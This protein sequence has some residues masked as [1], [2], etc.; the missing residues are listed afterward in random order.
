MTMTT[1]NRRLSKAA[2]KAVKSLRRQ[3]AKAAKA[4]EASPEMIKLVRS[5]TRRVREFNN[6]TAEGTR[7]A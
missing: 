1:N 3:A 6:Y 4:G 2:R 5:E 7:Y